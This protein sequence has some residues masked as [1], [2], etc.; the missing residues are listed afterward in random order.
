MLIETPPV[1][2]TPPVMPDNMLLKGK[3]LVFP[4]KAEENHGSVYLIIINDSL[5]YIIIRTN[6]MRKPHTSFLGKNSSLLR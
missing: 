5:L 2:L 3:Q 4:L 1:A 6:A